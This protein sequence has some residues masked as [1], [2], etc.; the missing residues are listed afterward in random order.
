MDGGVDQGPWLQE[1]VGGG[2]GAGW[3]FQRRGRV[4]AWLAVPKSGKSREGLACLAVPQEGGIRFRGVYRILGG[5][6]PGKGWLAWQFHRSGQ[7][8]GGESKGLGCGRVG[9]LFFESWRVDL[10]T[11]SPVVWG[12]G[13]GWLGGARAWGGFLSFQT[14]TKRRKM[15]F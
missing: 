10:V 11:C 14:Q 4:G 3:Q 8:L 9:V 6:S 13:K 15:A 7:G 2:V 1:R 5:A 12:S